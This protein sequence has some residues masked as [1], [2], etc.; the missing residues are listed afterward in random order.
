MLNSS[1][2]EAELKLTLQQDQPNRKVWL[3]INK[4]TERQES[5]LKFLEEVMGNDGYFGK[6][7]RVRLTS[8]FSFSHHVSLIMSV[9]DQL[10]TG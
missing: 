5:C 10:V 3:D 1:T 8:L 9:V 2:H 7:V 6:F 4:S